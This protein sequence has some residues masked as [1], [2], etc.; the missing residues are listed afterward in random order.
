[1]SWNY[2]SIAFIQLL[3]QS[4]ATAISID[5]SL[6][7][8]IFSLQMNRRWTPN[9]AKGVAF[10]NHFPHFPENFLRP[11]AVADPVPSTDTIFGRLR[12]E[13]CEWPPWTA[14]SELYSTLVE[15]RPCLNN[16]THL[17]DH[18]KMTTFLADLEAIT[19][20]LAKFHKDSDIFKTD[21]DSREV[22]CAIANTHPE[23]M[24][25]TRASAHIRG[26]LF[27]MGLQYL[28][29]HTV[30]TNPVHLPGGMSFALRPDQQFKRKERT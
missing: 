8:F 1:M 17:L 10:F 21:E 27:S 7:T 28:V 3:S 5:V 15:N 11:Y 14:T 19:N 16:D 18:E 4:P 22:I 6:T 12:L 20:M 26:A 9:K 30:L 24:A 25:K 23:V 29:A 2:S 13:G